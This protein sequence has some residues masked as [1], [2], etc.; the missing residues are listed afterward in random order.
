MHSL[1]HPGICTTRR[2]IT[3]R[4][5][6][7]KLWT[8]DCLQC[9]TSKTQP[10]SS[11]PPVP[12]P[13]PSLRFSHIH[14]DLVD[15]LT[16]SQGHTHILTVTDRT[17][18]W[19]EATPLSSTSAKSCADALCSSSISHFALPH[20]I[21]SDRDPQFISQSHWSSESTVCFLPR[22]SAV[23]ILGDAQTHN[24]TE[25]LLFALSRYNTF[26]E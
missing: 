23:C 14:V 26:I 25:F 21:T 24:G 3:F 6:W 18:C 5:L 15:P 12:I 17:T 10:H 19:A 16:P 1:G 11:P 13:I 4:F 2:L 22:G 20:T 8:K 9:Q 7:E